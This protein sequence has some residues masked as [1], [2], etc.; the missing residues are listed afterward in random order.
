[1]R[2]ISVLF[3]SEKG[4]YCNLKNLDLW[5]ETRDARN[6]IGMNPVICHPPCTRWCK[7]TFAIYG[8]EKSAKFFPGNDNGCFQSAL[9][10]VN[11]CGG[12]LEHPACS[13]AWK[14]FN[15]TKPIKGQWTKCGHGYVCEVYQSAYGHRAMKP[16]W[17]YYRGIQ[18][19]FD[20][21]WIYKPGSHQVAARNWKIPNAKPQ[22]P[23][24]ERIGTP[25]AFRDELLKLAAYSRNW[26]LKIEEE[27]K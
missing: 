26:K 27:A 25:K 24:E 4:S 12:V 3:V 13:F 20:L 14:V 5:P 22:L 11:R 15:L 9:I 21:K 7:L 6:Y 18:E 19:P 10:N 16:T 1:M 2:Q 17:L 8:K 23:F